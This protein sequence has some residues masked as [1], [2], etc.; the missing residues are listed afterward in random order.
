MNLWTWVEGRKKS[1]YEKMLLAQSSWLKF[2]CYLLRFSRGAY[3]DPHTDPAQPGYRH[4]RLNIYLR[5][6]R[7]GGVFSVEKSLFRNGAFCLFRP[8]LHEHSVSAVEAGT[9]YVLSIG[10]LLRQ[11]VKHNVFD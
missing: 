8:D 4:F 11:P 10:W 9:R 3:I 5:S 1:R 2:D 7:R 6:A